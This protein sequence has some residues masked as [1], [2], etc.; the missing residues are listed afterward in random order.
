MF[1]LLFIVCWFVLFGAICSG[2]AK[3]KNLDPALWFFIGGVLGIIG[4]ILAAIVPAGN[5]AP[6]ARNAPGKVCPYCG[7]K[8]S[9]A[10][11]VCQ[12]CGRGQPDFGTASVGSWE[13]TVR[14][15]DDVDKWAREH[16]DQQ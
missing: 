2:M 9:V 5:S 6:G 11:R 12:A 15:G 13:Q 14:R 8:I 7:Q 3:A 4:V 1:Y 10:D 16:P